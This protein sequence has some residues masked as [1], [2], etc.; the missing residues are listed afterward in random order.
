[1]AY[2]TISDSQVDID[3]PIDTDLMQGLRDN[4]RELRLQVFA[5][6]VPET[7]RNSTSYRIA[8]TQSVYIPDYPDETGWTKHL[9]IEVDLKT[10]NASGAAIYQL[11]DSSS[12]NTS[13]EVSTTFTTYQA[14]DNSLSIPGAWAG[15]TRDI[16]VKIK[17]ANASYTTTIKSE[18]RVTAR[19]YY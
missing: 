19:L 11:E 6:Y 13:S 14:A 7:T 3:S 18:D 2:T 16:L 5:C 4:A 1:M 15:T 9:A 8:S 17:N 12:G 10:D